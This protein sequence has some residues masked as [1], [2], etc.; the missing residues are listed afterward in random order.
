MDKSEKYVGV[1]HVFMNY[2]ALAV[3]IA[4]LWKKIGCIPELKKCE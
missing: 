1:I 2:Y 3:I 4:D